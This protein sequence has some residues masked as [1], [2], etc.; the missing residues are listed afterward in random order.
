MRHAEDKKSFLHLRLGQS[1]KE[2]MQN[3]ARRHHTTIS[4]LVI[5]FFQALLISEEEKLNPP[6][7][8]QI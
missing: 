7:A 4:A 5:R 1:L 3:Y 2:Q 6:D 8:D